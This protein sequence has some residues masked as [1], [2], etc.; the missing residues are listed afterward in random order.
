MMAWDDLDLNT[1]RDET[2][3]VTALLKS[4]PLER[5]GPPRC[6]RRGRGPGRA[7]P[8]K[9]PAA[10]AW[11][12]ASCRSS[13][14]RRREGLALMC[15]AEALL[16]T[17]DEATRD[18][19][20]A[21]KIGSADWASHLGQSGQP[22]RQRLD[23]GAD[24]HRQ[25]G[26]RGRGRP[27]PTCRASSRRLAG[28][29]GRAGD[30]PRGRP[31]PSASWASSSCSAAPSRRRSRARRERLRLLLRHAGRGR[32]HRRRRRPLRGGLC[33]GDR[34]RRR[35]AP[36]A[37][38]RRPATAFRSSCR[39]CRRAMRP[40]Q[41]R[42]SGPSSIRACCAWP[43]WPPP[44]DINFTIDAEEAD[45]LALSLKLLDRLAREPDLGDWTRPGP[46]GPGLSEAR[47][48]R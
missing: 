34:R 12:R 13:R 37:P 2:E 24:A 10:R 25:A 40:T 23:L 1:Y 20:I 35:S 5:R 38:G 43:C 3:A 48:R 39:R 28:A 29:A 22:V 26:G 44:A 33:R 41:E 15:L 11:S 19:L 21:E 42:G 30:P 27:T 7:P 6:P 9:P 8:D 31:R 17:P 32:A 45:R 4:A 18:K 46:G 14:S 36:A 16:R 47:R